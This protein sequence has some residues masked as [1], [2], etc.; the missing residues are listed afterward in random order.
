MK[1]K[2]KAEDF[3]AKSIEHLLDRKFIVDRKSLCIDIICDAYVNSFVEFFYLTHRISES[4]KVLDSKMPVDQLVYIKENLVK[5]ESAHRQG[6]SKAMH[7]A[8][9]N[10]GDFYKQAKEYRTAIYF[11]IKCRDVVAGI[12]D[13]A[14]Q[15]VAFLE[16]G[17]TYECANE[18][19]KAIAAHEQHLRIAETMESEF[20]MI[21]ASRNLVRTYKLHAKNLM[22]KGEHEDSLKF[23]TKCIENGKASGDHKGEAQANLMI[24]RIHAS[25]NNHKDGICFFKQYLKLCLQLEDKNGEGIAYYELGMAFK[26]TNDKVLATKYLESYLKVCEV[27]NKA[28][29][30]AQACSALGLIHSELGEYPEA[31]EFY[32]RKFNLVR[33]F[34]HKSKLGAAR[35]DLGVAKGRNTINDFVD[36]ILADDLQELLEWKCSRKHGDDEEGGEESLTNPANEKENKPDGAPADKAEDKEES[37]L[38]P[39]LGHIGH[40]GEGK[41][42]SGP[43]EEG[44]KGDD[45]ECVGV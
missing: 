1:R 3:S 16:L 6:D 19:E 40:K 15:L 2:K 30:T 5:A 36:M 4:G 13:P 45:E 28:D 39:P 42:G 24:G 44:E 34:D 17:L 18:V 23:L 35:V 32:D 9:K 33:K 21:Q 37:I 25:K 8:Y 31:I 41:S 14:L 12:Q 20:E 43:H 38:P 27:Q 26:A 29:S 10:I 22:K 11:Y 7:S